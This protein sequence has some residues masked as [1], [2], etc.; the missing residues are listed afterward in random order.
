M[1]MVQP[2]WHGLFDHIEVPMSASWSVGDLVPCQECSQGSSVTDR[3]FQE[4]QNSAL[5]VQIFSIPKIRSH[6]F[7]INSWKIDENC[8][9]LRSAFLALKQQLSRGGSHGLENRCEAAAGP[10]SAG[11]WKGSRKGSRKGSQRSLT[12]GIFES[13]IL[14]IIVCISFFGGISWV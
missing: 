14:F 10:S 2:V 7:N 6:K 3:H 4:L 1:N 8:F 5:G 11:S 13:Q 12:P 9:G